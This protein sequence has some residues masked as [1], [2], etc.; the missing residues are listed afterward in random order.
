MRQALVEA[1]A[2][3]FRWDSRAVAL[4]SSFLIKKHHF[5]MKVTLTHRNGRHSLRLLQCR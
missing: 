1:I 4:K 2:A 3:M 5:D